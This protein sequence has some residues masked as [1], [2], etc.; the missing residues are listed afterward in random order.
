[1]REAGVGAHTGREIEQVLCAEHYAA[2][3]YG[4]VPAEASRFSTAVL[5]TV[6]YTRRIGD[7]IRQAIQGDTRTGN[8]G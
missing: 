6:K 5:E 1:M 3:R 4:R 8:R 7:A 2:A